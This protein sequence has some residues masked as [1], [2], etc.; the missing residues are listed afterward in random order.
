MTTAGKY[1]F[2]YKYLEERYADRVVLTLAQ[3]EDLLGFALPPSA[4]ADPAWWADGPT[5]NRE[6][7]CCSDAWTLA[8]R[9][10]MPNLG[11][12]NVVFDR[13]G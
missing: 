1:Q 8:H 3:I 9:T 5:E 7:A 10:A 2:L 4:H 13:V 12:G 11:A 6:E